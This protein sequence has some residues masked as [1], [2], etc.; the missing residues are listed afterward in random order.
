MRG[1]RVELGGI[2]NAI[3]DMGLAMQCAVVAKKLDVDDVRLVAFVVKPTDASVSAFRRALSTQLPDYMLPQQVVVL[4]AMPLTVNGKLDRKRLQ[5]MPWEPQLTFAHRAPP[6]TEVERTIA[7]VFCNV[8]GVNEVNVDEDFFDLGG[9]SLLA[10]I[11]IQAIEKALGVTFPPHV[12]FERPT[13]RGLAVY[14]SGPLAAES[15]PILLNEKCAAPPLFMLSGIHIYRA[16]A[17]RLEGRYPAYGVFAGS[18]LGTHESVSTT[19]SVEQLAREYV[20]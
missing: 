13:V 12:L 18:E 3:R 8:L 4:D 6:Q 11:A 5:E 7:G 9:H 14:A 20:K 15:R 19:H 10:V 2:E 17:R 16:L 1:I